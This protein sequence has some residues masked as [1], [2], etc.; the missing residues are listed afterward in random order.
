MRPAIDVRRVSAASDQAA[1]DSQTPTPAGPRDADQQMSDVREAFR[2]RRMARTQR[3]LYG[4]YIEHNLLDE[5]Q[6]SRRLVLELLRAARMH[7]RRT[8]CMTP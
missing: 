7:W 5:A 8:L 3:H 4:F 2:L 1:R 6:S